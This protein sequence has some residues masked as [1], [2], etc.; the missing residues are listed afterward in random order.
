[1]NALHQHTLDS[2]RASRHGA[3]VPPRPGDHDWQAARELTSQAL[4]VRRAARVRRRR[5]GPSP[6]RS[7]LAGLARLPRLLRA[8]R[9]AARN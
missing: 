7:L 4:L 5:P 8:P 2:Y 9:S 1:M 3:P 6:A